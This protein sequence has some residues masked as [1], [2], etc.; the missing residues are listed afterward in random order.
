MED[1]VPSTAFSEFANGILT[2]AN[3]ADDLLKR[4]TPWWPFIPADS[5]EERSRILASVVVTV[6]FGRLTPCLSGE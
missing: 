5:C 4:K 3:G 1:L 6:V 2:E